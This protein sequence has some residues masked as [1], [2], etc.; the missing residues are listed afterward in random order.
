MIDATAF[1]PIDLGDFRRGGSRRRR[2]IAHTV[3]DVCRST[4]FL[5]IRNH[6]VPAATIDAA[7]QA[8]RGFFDRPLQEKMRLAPSD[9]GN[10][11]GYFPTARETL[12]LSRGVAGPPDLKEAFSAGPPA[13]PGAL[14]D[15]PALAFF[16]GPNAWP[17]RPR[18]FR[19]AWLDY[20]R[21]MEQLSAEI[22]TVFAAALGLPDDHFVPYFDHH[23]S[24][25]RALNY[26]TMAA[27]SPLAGAR[28]G[29]HSDYGS[30]TVLR[31]DPD[32]AGLEIEVR[33]GQWLA[34]PSVDDGFIVNI[35]D[36]MAR[37]T[38][39]RW[40]STVHRVAPSDPAGEAPRRQ[41]IAFFHNPGHAAVIECLPVCVE[42]GHEPGYTPVAAGAYLRS[43]FTAA[44]AGA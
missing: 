19:D 28:A 2:E 37:W 9:P 6:G 40:R 4:G 22:M 42:P 5:V 36:L 30:L 23:V 1:A 12:T 21:A 41:S 32:V 27:D 35:G 29:A 25:L 8:A 11:R 34:A 39:D 43:R 17:E 13:V 33:P 14:R 7:W 15:D 24:A 20:Y 38:N 3:D 16:Y 31:P 44:V 26:P 18:G 10:P